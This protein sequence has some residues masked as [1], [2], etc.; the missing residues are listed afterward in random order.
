MFAF[1]NGAQIF[2]T[3]ANVGNPPRVPMETDYRIGISRF[4]R[5]LLWP[6]SSAN[7]TYTNTYTSRTNLAKSPMKTTHKHVSRDLFW[8]PLIPF[9]ELDNS[10]HLRAVKPWSDILPV[11]PANHRRHIPLPLALPHDRAPS[12]VGLCLLERPAVASP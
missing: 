2:A 6:F 3:A 12:E 7:F 8:A 11:R 5:P 10:K 1:T 4:R 9:K